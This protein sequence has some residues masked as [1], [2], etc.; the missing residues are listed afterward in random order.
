[1][2]GE[3]RLDSVLRFDYIC[4]W[5]VIERWVGDGSSEAERQRGV[6]G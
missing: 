4:R 2:S 5:Q 6:V 3:V 1:M